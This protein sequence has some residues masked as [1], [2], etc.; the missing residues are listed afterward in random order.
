MNK[1][2]YRL[3][4]L[5]AITGILII[6]ILS[7]VY[8]LTDGGSAKEDKAKVSGTPT[9]SSGVTQTED[10]ALTA[11][12]ETLHSMNAIIK[13]IDLDNAIVTVRER[14]TEA[15]YEFTYNG[16]TDIRT[17]YDRQITA[18]MLKPGDFV[19]LSYNDGYLLRSM[20]GSKDVKIYKNILQR[21]QDDSLRKITVGGTIYRYGDDLLVLNEGYFVGIDTLREMSGGY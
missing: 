12:D 15:E 5:V 17:A 13:G 16:A 9:P 10:P 4:I 11:P 21:T 8:V 3:P 18:T 19:D 20:T 1:G 2:N 14:G 7:V 6:I